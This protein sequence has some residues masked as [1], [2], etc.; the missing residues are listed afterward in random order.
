MEAWMIHDIP[1]GEAPKLKYR[2]CKLNIGVLPNL[3][4][5][6]KTFSSTLLRPTLVGRPVSIVV[7]NL[8]HNR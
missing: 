5:H 1:F 4:P 3:G 8:Q 6:R 2:Y 7:L